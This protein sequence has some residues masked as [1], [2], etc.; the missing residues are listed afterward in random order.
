LS[1]IKVV[2]R[3][4]TVINESKRKRKYKRNAHHLTEGRSLSDKVS[5]SGYTEVERSEANS[6]IVTVDDEHLSFRFHLLI[7]AAQKLLVAVAMMMG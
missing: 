6:V 2:V 4:S 5:T 3:Q 1:S 7:R